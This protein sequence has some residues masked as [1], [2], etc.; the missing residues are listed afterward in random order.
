MAQN[1]IV[2]PPTTRIEFRIWTADDFSNAITLWGDEQVTALLGGPFTRERIQQ[3]FELELDELN[4]SG[5]QYWALYYRPTG[6]FVGCCGIHS[7]YSAIPGDIELGYHL[8]TKFWGQGIA[9]EAANAVL[10]HAFNT[11]K[12]TKVTA[13]HHP[14]NKASQAILTNKLKMNPMGD[15]FYPPTG[16]RHPVY[17]INSIDF[18]SRLLEPANSSK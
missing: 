18:N 11:L 16:L 15:V 10:D 1:L 12:Y 14:D 17:Y 3:R 6:E 7:I 9:P 4:K 5:L 8:R 2:P 13:G